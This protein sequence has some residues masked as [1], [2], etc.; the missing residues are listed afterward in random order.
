MKLIHRN[1]MAVK[2]HM[3]INDRNTQGFLDLGPPLPYSPITSPEKQARYLIAAHPL[4]GSVVFCKCGQA[5][6]DNSA[7]SPLLSCKVAVVR[8]RA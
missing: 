6:E 7:V 3:F 1:E 2:P 8:S 4:T 5:A